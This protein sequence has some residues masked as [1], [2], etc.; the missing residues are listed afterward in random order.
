[1]PLPDV[2]DRQPIHT[3]AVTCR[4]WRRADGLW[5]IEGHLTDTKAYG[6]PNADRGEIAAGEPIHEM[7]LRLTL[8]DDLLV[9]DVVAVT[10]A[11][12]FAVCPAITPNF[13]RLVGLRIG[14]GWRRAIAERLGG[15][16][17]CTHLV[18]LLGPVAT[19]AYQTIYP[20]VAREK[21]RTAGDRP[22][23]H[24][25]SCH[26]LARDGAVVR[27]EYPRWYTGPDAPVPAEGGVAPK[28]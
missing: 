11:A 10:D 25:D 13:R 7:W 8:D 21:A 16:E 26:A 18:E 4:G 22:P 14:R 15:V 23:S 2:A 20:I 1:M 9:H 12:P 6:F 28:A 17:G 3:R 19:T 27:R 24:L 5:D